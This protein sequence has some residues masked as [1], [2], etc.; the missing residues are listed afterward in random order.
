MS[1]WTWYARLRS[2]KAYRVFRAL[3][4]A[5]ILAALWVAFRDVTTPGSWRF[6]ILVLAGFAV[7]DLLED[8]KALVGKRV[9]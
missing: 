6:W 5:A 7:V 4:G 1:Y 3:C 2:R 8:L 9:E